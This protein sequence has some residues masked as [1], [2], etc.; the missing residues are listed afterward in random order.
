[1]ADVSPRS[2][3]LRDVSRGETSAVRRLL[4][5]VI[6]SKGFIVAYESQVSHKL[7][8]KNINIKGL[9]GILAIVIQGSKIVTNKALEFLTLS[10]RLNLWCNDCFL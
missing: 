1:M 5:A 6:I 10:P 8:T 2:S 7:T 9:Y 3:P 4:R